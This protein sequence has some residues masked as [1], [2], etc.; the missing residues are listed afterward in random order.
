MTIF[1]ARQ[2]LMKAK[3][4]APNSPQEIDTHSNQ[5]MYTQIHTKLKKL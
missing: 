5:Y 1:L 4:L 3:L 2:F